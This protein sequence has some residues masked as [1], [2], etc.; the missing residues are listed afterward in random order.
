M[1]T[2]T[3][4]AQSALNRAL[5]ERQLLLCRVPMAVVDTA[6]HLVGLQAQSPLAPYVG[7]WTR[8]ERFDPAE[9]AGLL[10]ER[11]MVRTPAMRTTIHLF[12]ARDCLALRPLFDGLL[13]RTFASSAFDVGGVDLDALTA[14]AVA[15]LEQRPR[16]RGELGGLLARTRPDSDPL[17]LS[18][19]L[20][21]LLPLVQTP[22]RAVWG[23]ASG[24]KPTW[25]LTR[26]WLGADLQATTL[27]EL[28]LR[29]LAAFGPA[30]V[31]DI[32]L[33]S[34]LTKLKEVVEEL[35]DR[36]LELRG[37]NGAVLFDLPDALRPDPDTPAPPRF[38]PEYDN[39]LLSHADR[40]RVNP[41]GRR[42]P[43]PPGNGA[44]AGTLLVDGTY[45]A[46]W[47]LVRQGDTAVLQIEPFS[48]LASGDTEAV[49]R[50]G[51]Q[52]L[53]FIAEGAEHDVRIVGPA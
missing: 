43:L 2:P 45:S 29:Y 36:L 13:A 42:V 24:S 51:A 40:S 5:L 11:A 47:K 4:L 15:L 52:L 3:V 25:A 35:G 10:T 50:E 39:V 12:T 44:R 17:A 48:A 23:A 33:W 18:Y 31:A 37:E 14:E 28:V 32:Q 49:E 26:T 9:L 19:A 34:G 41:E 1:T 21:H 6:E 7:L 8:L 27:R 38:L 53:R 16:T 46:D 30:T 22:P 20:Q